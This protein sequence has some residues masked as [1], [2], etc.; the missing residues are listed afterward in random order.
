MHEFRALILAGGKSSRMGR[1]KANL[2]I[3]GQT[4]LERLILTVTP[5]VSEIMVMLSAEQPLPT[6]HTDL[7]NRIRIGR[8]SKA[9][10]G[11]LQGIADAVL[12]FS[13]HISSIFVLTC[14]LPFLNS[15]WLELM[16]Q[17]HRENNSIVCAEYE[18]VS[19]PLLAIYPKEK[20]VN[21]QSYLDS[22]ERSCLVL[23][24]DTDVTSLPAQKDE[25]FVCKDINTP[26][27]FEKAVLFLSGRK[28]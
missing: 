1:D 14:D 4:L 6:L 18:A 5:L 9:E 22:G 20:L 27:E 15:R 17:K 3:N 16:K 11:P 26:T 8:D 12:N 19:N 13:P 28:S 7:L 2:V 10:Q 25:P 21:A 23:I 24:K